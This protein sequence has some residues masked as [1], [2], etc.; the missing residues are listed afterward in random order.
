MQRTEAR[1]AGTNSRPSRRAFL[2]SSA[3]VG[4]GLLAGCLGAGASTGGRE[5]TIG[6]QPFYAQAWSAVVIKNGGLAEESLP[7]GYSVKNWDSALQG[8]I[9]GTRMIS[10]KNQIGYA[11][12]MPTITTIANDR[13]PIDVVGTAGYSRGQ[14]CNLAFVPNGS[15]IRTAKQI[16]NNEVHMTTGT[17]T[18]R[19]YLNMIRRVGIDPPLV[20]AGMGNIL[21][22]IRQGAISVGFGWE[23]SMARAVIQEDAARYLISGAQYISGPNQ[24]P[25]VVDA[26]G[27]LML[28]SLVEND[29]E[30]AIGWLKAELE[31]KRIMA[32]QPERTLDLVSQEGDLSTYDRSTLH[33]CLYEN[34]PINPN[35]NRLEFLTDYAAIDPANRLLREKGPQFLKNQG[36]ITEI[37]PPRRY[38][39]QLTQQAAEELGVNTGLDRFGS[40]SGS[41]N[42]G[43]A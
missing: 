23:P 33:A 14:Q 13:T 5:L 2:G 39:P 16:A 26:A 1:T 8:S 7:S 10:G 35:V 41:K 6:Y 32:T 22:Q 31:A 25:D 43:Q 40:S 4:A 34:L 3:A 20:D 37:P 36:A 27:I 30:A 28:N 38:K 15:P 29:R 9:V 42:G 19:F 11:G 21:A 12:D 18:H 24:A 17:C